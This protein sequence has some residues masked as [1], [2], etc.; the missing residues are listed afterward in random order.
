MKTQNN[1]FLNST[2][3]RSLA[4]VLDVEFKTLMYNL[5]II[6]DNNKYTEFEVKKKNGN[7]RQICAPT[8]GIKYIQRNLADILLNIY[9]AKACVHGFVKEKGIK[10][11]AQTHVKKK[12]LINIDLKDFFYSINFGRVLGLFKSFPF[13]FNQEVA[14][15]LAQICCYK[16]YLPQGAPTSPIISNFICWNLDKKLMLFAKKTKLTYSRYADDITFSTNLNY[17]PN[18]IGTIIDEKL[19]LSSELQ[20]IVTSNG[21]NINKDK[22]R[23]A[24]KNNRKE[25]TGLIVNEKI[26]VNRK[27]IRHIRAMLHACEKFGISRAADEHFI[28]YNYK[29]KKVS[30]TINSFKEELI[31]KI[32]FIG[33]IKGKNDPVYISLFKRLKVI[34]PEANLKTI[35]KLRFDSQKPIIIGEG[36]TDWKHLKKAL[37]TFKNKGLFKN[38]DVQFYESN[39]ELGCSQL[40]KVCEG[41][42]LLD[43]SYNE[44][45][46]VF[47]RDVNPITSKFKNKDIKYFGNNVY[48]ILLPVPEKIKFKEISIE[49]YYDDDTLSRKDENGRRLFLSTEFNPDTKEHYHDPLISYQGGRIISAYPKIIDDK[50]IKKDKNIALP[51][52]KFANHIYEGHPSFKDVDFENFKLFYNLVEDVLSRKEFQEKSISEKEQPQKLKLVEE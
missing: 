27:Y 23:Y 39:E 42:S 3:K 49:H 33:H 43:F 32:G 18:E 8:S 25:V 26:N 9:N 45:I 52:N 17:I 24:L 35:E 29:N 14:T 22:I 28:K 46:A 30:N 7:T 41:T 5:H 51:K 36:K 40:M 1:L 4:N 21:F 34:I 11:N 31:G 2:D 47:D 20:H 6:S 44:I 13:N 15:T 37:N 19:E 10:T 48:G 38:I 16:G 50:V 12:I